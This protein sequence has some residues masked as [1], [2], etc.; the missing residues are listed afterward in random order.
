M[1][2]IAAAQIAPV[3]LNREATVAKTCD[4]ITQAAREGATGFVLTARAENHIR[5][6]PDLEDTKARLAA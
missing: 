6:N 4:C 5:G 3:F 1:T 2:K